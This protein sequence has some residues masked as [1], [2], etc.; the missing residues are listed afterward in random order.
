MAYSK[1]VK[2]SW[3]KHQINTQYIKWDKRKYCTETNK[4]CMLSQYTIHINKSSF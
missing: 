4:K 2:D 3:Y 1:I